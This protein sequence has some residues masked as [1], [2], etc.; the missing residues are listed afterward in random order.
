MTESERRVHRDD[1]GNG[2]SGDERVSSAAT[3][4]PRIGRFVAATGAES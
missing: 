3:P 1:G 2:S 4:T